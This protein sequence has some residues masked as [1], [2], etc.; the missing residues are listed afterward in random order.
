MVGIGGNMTIVVF[1]ARTAITT[2]KATDT[3]CRTE[4]NLP[5]YNDRRKVT[6]K[7]EKSTQRS[8]LVLMFQQKNKLGVRVLARF[9][10]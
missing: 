6:V 7:T 1:S 10:T 2:M 4:T 9:S 3:E 8:E 5:V